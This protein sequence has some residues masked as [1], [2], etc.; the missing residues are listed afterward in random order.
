MSVYDT[1]EVFIMEKEKFKARL[2][3]DANDNT[4]INVANPKTKTDAVNLDHFDYY[5][6]VIVKVI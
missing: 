5:T 3:F 1:H 4:I 6:I 2:G